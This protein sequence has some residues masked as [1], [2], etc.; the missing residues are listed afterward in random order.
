MRRDGHV[1]DDERATGRD[2]GTRLGGEVR[3]DAE[4]RCEGLEVRRLGP[5]DAGGRQPVAPAGGIN[6]GK[7][8]IDV[9]AAHAPVQI[10][11]GAADLDA[12]AVHVGM[13]IGRAKDD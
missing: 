7:G 6:S 8:G 1:G 12:V 10:E 3:R 2:R 13:P 5:A 11:A 4:S 9:A